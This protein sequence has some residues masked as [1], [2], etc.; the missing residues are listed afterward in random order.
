MKRREFI[1]LVGGAAAS[2]IAARAQ[3]PE[4]ARRIGVLVAGTATDPEYQKRIA[5]FQEGL[6]E[7][8][9][10]DGGNVRIDY[11][12][13]AGDADQIRRSAAELVALAPDV[14]FAGAGSAMGAL[15]Q[16]T[17]TIPIVFA[18]VTDPVGAG[19]VDS[20]ARPGGNVTG[21]LPFE[22][23]IAGKW[24]ELL[25]QIAPPLTRAA[26][27]RDP[28]SSTGIG[29]WAVIDA[30]APSIGVELSLINI[31]DAGEIERDIAAF[32][33]SPNGGLI[34][35]ATPLATQHRELIIRLAS[36]HKLPAV[37]YERYYVTGG[38]LVSYGPHIVDQ[39]RRAAGYVDRILKG[40]KPTDL[41]VQ[42][43]TKYE[44]VVNLKTA[45]AL[46]IEVPQTL[47]A[48]ADDII[49]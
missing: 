7:L 3:Q 13:G 31:R 39:F 34:V 2:P 45:R 19:Y 30:M 9:W 1:A 43:P 38:G 15:L 25:K 32:A 22:Y 6:H 26:I 48:R 14:I 4:R 33:R 21:F 16:A 41:P 20:L 5:A 36:E 18:I 37:Y 40:E 28:N 47:L 35:T 8:G 10:T 17:R 46:G 27:I 11:A 49:E 23:G 24:L 29:Q 44:L 12:R 42:G